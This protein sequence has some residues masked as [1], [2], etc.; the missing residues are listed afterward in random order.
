MKIVVYW[1]EQQ[2][3]KSKLRRLQSA[4]PNSMMVLW[5]L[6]KRNQKN[7]QTLLAEIPGCESFEENDVTEWVISD[8]FEVGYAD[9]DI[10]DLLLQPMDGYVREDNDM[11]QTT[12][13][14]QPKM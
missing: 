1:C 6:V 7:L 13:V 10:S 5:S 12:P 8:D 9:N 11:K 2:W 3:D 4:G 14:L